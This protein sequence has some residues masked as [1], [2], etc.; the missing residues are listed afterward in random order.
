MIDEAAE[1]ISKAKNPVVLVGN[2]AVQNHASEALAHFAEGLKLPV[3]NTMM[4]KGM[5]PYISKYSLWTIGIPQKDFSNKVLEKSDLIIA[6]GYDIVEYAP[7]KWNDDPHRRIIH[8]DTRPAH[9][10]KLYQPATEV[11][12][13]ISY[14]LLRILKKSSRTEEPEGAL[15]IKRQMV[16]DHEAYSADT[17]YPPKP[18]K[19][20]HDIRT[21]LREDGILISDVGAHKV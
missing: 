11:V 1:L 4:A 18:Q 16:R 15:R 19:I 20:L 8:I 10:N 6:V 14:S 21:V 9:I 13:D 5:I 12:G 17:S 3:V 7:N 2:S